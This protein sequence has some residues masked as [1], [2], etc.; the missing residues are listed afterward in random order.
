MTYCTT[1]REEGRA[2]ASNKHAEKIWFGVASEIR[3]RG[4]TN[5]KEAVLSQS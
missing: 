3:E 5:N 2:T 1:P 4:Q